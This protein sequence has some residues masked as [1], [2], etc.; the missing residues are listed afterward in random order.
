MPSSSF[1]S[2]AAPSPTPS[3]RA[4]A[5]RSPTPP[6]PPLVG[7]LIESLSFRGCGFGRAAASAFEKEDL[8]SR[9]ALPRR[10]RAAVHAAM[11]AR[12]PAAGA[13]ALDDRDGACNPWFDAAAHDDAPESPLVAF[14]NPRSGGRLGP[15]LKTR[16]QELIGEDQ[17]ALV[18]SG[19]LRRSAEL[20]DALIRALS[21]SARPH[22]AHPLYAHLLRAGLLPTPHTLPSLLKSVALSLA[23]PGAS[24]LALAVHAHAV[25]LGLERFLLVSNALIRVH[26]GLLGRLDDGLLLLRT[27][28]AVDAASFNTLITAYARAGRVADARKLFDE[29]PAKN[30]VSWSAMV[31]GYVQAGDGREALEIF[32]RMQAEGVCPDDTVLV[33]VLAA[34]AQHGALE[35]GK[36]V[37]GYLKA[38]DTRITVFL[39]TAL[40]DMYAKCGEVQLAMD[41]FEAMKDKN[42]LAWTTM[43]K[44]LAIHGRG[45][46]A[47]TLFSQMESSGV[48]PDDIAF[49]GALCACTHAGLVDKGRELFD[50][51]VRKYGIRPKIEHY[52]C[53]VDLLARNGLLGEAKEMVQKMPMKPD[54]LIWGALMAGCRFHK[55]VELAEYVVKHWILLEP[56][57]SGAY[58]LLANIYAASGRHNSA[59]EIRHLMREKGVDKTP[60]CSTVEM[61]GIIHQFIVGDLSHPRIKDILAKWHEIDSRNAAQIFFQLLMT[62]SVGIQTQIL[63]AALSRHSEKLAIAFALIS[64][65][66]DM[67]IRI[68]KNLRVCH[69]CHHVTKLISKVFDLTVVKPS[70]FVEYALACLEQLADSGDHSAGFVRNNLRVMVAGG[71]GT[72]GWVLGCLGELYVQNREPVPPVA[73]IPLGTGNDLSRSFGWGASFSFSWKAAAKRSLYKAIFGSVSCLDSWHVVVSMPEDG[74]EEKEELDL[75]HSLRHLGGCTFFDDGTAKGELPETVSCFD[76]VFYN[77]FSIGMDAQVAYGFHQLRDEKPF[78]ANGPLSNKLIYAGYTCKQGWFF[79]QCISDPELRGLRNII[80]LSI[81]RMDSS[82]WESIPVPSSV[83]AIVALNL[84][85]Y[86]SGRNPWGNLKPEYL[87]KKGF[88]E[89]HSDDGLLEIFGLKQGWHASLVMVELI[90][91][92]HIAQAAAIRIEIKG[93]QWRDAFMQMDGEPWKQPLSSEYSTFVDIKKVP[94]PSLIING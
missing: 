49:I 90:S 1:S 39:G 2:S 66:V 82:E 64:T 28:A 42:V 11:R 89:A 72:V 34:C 37:H 87:E 67:P 75:P 17:A 51:M 16:L 52:G 56:D 47:L 31:N 38:N 50:S 7:A 4:E 88:V 15:V 62:M 40:V 91:A 21:R 73:V 3:E 10:L 74:E 12:D 83:R 18:T 84:H 32:A 14:V 81:K 48:R 78:L 93:G 13:F 22:L 30:A 55:N 6:A 77:Y 41:V 24:A 35:Q 5:P 25:K 61:K 20:H 27:A 71:D 43:I 26:A 60:G 33:G 44:G 45:S 53:M 8:R 54:A 36:W 58:V 29:M 23:A 80:C 76:G 19:R 65:S 94:Y 70:E 85:N 59:R 92:K 63:F 57:K 9:A 69:D 86:A 68:V 46:E 79:T